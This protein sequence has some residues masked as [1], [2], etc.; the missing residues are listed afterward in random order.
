MTDPHIS[1][2]D[3]LAPPEP[4]DLPDTRPPLD[5]PNVIHQVNAIQSFLQQERRR[6]QQAD[7]DWRK[8]KELLTEKK[9]E[10]ETL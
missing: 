7:E 3:Q 2:S 10:T 4:R 9:Q 5:L 8:A 6:K 1:Q